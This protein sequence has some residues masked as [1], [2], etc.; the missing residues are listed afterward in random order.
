MSPAVRI[1]VVTFRR[2]VLLE[3]ALR[4]L[5][6]QTHAAWSAEVC[7]DDPADGRPAEVVRRLADPR[8]SLA[9]LG[10]R[11]GAA[12]R[13]NEAFR[14][15]PEPYAS[16]LEDD[17]WWEPAFLA[18]MV[19][20]LEARPDVALACGNERIW[21]EELDGAW[22]DTGRTIWPTDGEPTLFAWRDVDKCGGAKLCNSSLLFRTATA[23]AWRTPDDIP[24]DVTE[25]FRERL[26][27]HPFL[28]HPAALVNY[29]ETLQTNRARG[30]GI[31]G[32]YQ[33]LLVAS[34][35]ARRAMPER[36]ALAE[37]LWSR[38]RTVAPHSA[39]TCLAAALAQ[40]AARELLRTA[41]IREIARFAAGCVRHPVASWRA[42]R[43]PRLHPRAWAFLLEAARHPSPS[44]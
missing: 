24:V 41:R 43:A 39:T 14:P 19:A 7:N 23:A 44:P 18:T 33:V 28:L 3:R 16:L 42:T 15:G 21:R 6:A 31:W 38:V 13:F 9:P 1:T 20:A 8:I 12:A 37:A 27:P 36:R 34:V 10:P 17:N 4:S 40:P 32:E 5:V 29:A 11:R 25:H 2:P 22:T 26:I 30:P 35:F